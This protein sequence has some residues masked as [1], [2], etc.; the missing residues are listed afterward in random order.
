MSG[1]V[2]LPHA[3][4]VLKDGQVPYSEAF[5]DV[6]H[7]A[8][9]GPAQARHVFLQGNDLPR[10]WQDRRQFC[11]LETGFGLGL[12][13]L[14]TW[15]AFEQ[16][17]HGT[18]RLHF[19]SVENLPFRAADLM[20]AHGAWP[21]HAA[22]SRELLAQ[23]PLPLQG[24]HRLVLAEGR[25]ILTLLLGDALACLRELRARFDAIFLDGFAPARNPAM[26]SAELFGELARLSTPGTSLATWSVAA[27]VRRGLQ[28]AGFTLQRRPG[29][30]GK[31]EMLI[32]H[33]HAAPDEAPPPAIPEH[34]VVIGAGLAGSACAHALARRGIAVTVLDSHV[35]PAGEAS[36]NPLG[37]CAPLLNPGDAPNARLSR[38]AFLHAVRHYRSLLAQEP[39]A[40]QGGGVL[41]ILRGPAEATRYRQALDARRFP[42]EF[43]RFVPSGEMAV[44]AGHA[45]GHAGIWFAQGMALDPR[46]ACRRQLAHP[47]VRTVQHATVHALRHHGGSWVVHSEDGAILA[48]APWLVVAGGARCTDLLPQLPL[49]VVRGQVSLFPWPTEAALRC[50]VSGESYALMLPDGRLLVGATMQPGDADPAIREAD[51]ATN[52]QRLE[53]TFASLAGHAQVSRAEGRV[54]FRAVTP[55]RLPLVGAM[56]GWPAGLQV[57]AGLGARG[58]SWAPLAA[59]WLA[60]GLCGEPLPLP[61][62]LAGSFAASRYDTL[63][64]D[65]HIHTGTPPAPG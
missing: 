46:A 12:N 11:I 13:F 38:A 47:L 42:P 15:Q 21:A 37:L 59:E 5:G 2:S 64:R 49:Q 20:R 1:Y 61:A 4:L 17:A 3:S 10:R 35:A 54:G 28:A 27:T 62:D 63:S 51:H 8:A 53:A 16:A 6:Y 32:G 57:C 44:H 65:C 30:G 36:G 22:R 19:V 50:P 52:L 56:D 33:R 58:I 29:Y 31:R 7:S 25:V 14:E 40:A 23:W 43:A 24:Y 34:A 18:Q 26:W 45:C 39:A 41:R 48:Q 60:S 9:G 55:D